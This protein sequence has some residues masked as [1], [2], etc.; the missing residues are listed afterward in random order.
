MYVEVSV[1]W[2]LNRLT[3]VPSHARMQSRIVRTT[4]KFRIF[5]HVLKGSLGSLRGCKLIPPMQLKLT[6]RAGPSFEILRSFVFRHRLEEP[7]SL[8]IQHPLNSL[9]L[10]QTLSCCFG[11]LLTS[12]CSTVIVQQNLSI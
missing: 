10:H 6:P 7:S 5:T 9:Q 2:N 3:H 4:S 12:I 11:I 1:A 8:P